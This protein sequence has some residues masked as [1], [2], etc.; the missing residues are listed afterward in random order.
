MNQ[1]DQV[2]VAWLRG[3]E[4]LRQPDFPSPGRRALIHR[5][6]AGDALGGRVSIE[7]A[8]ALEPIGL[9]PMKLVLKLEHRGRG[10]PR[11][12]V[13]RAYED[14]K[15]GAQIDAETAAQEASGGRKPK[16]Y[17]VAEEVARKAGKGRSTGQAA[18]K[19]ARRAR[20]LDE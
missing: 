17:L 2:I 10:R 15:L 12:D 9:S 1:E 20:G 4:R 11:N 7:L 16:R 8:K 5:L 6:Q 14:L 19:T 3:K 13:R 18:R